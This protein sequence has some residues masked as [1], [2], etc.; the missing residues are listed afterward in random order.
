MRCGGPPGARAANTPRLKGKAVTDT[1]EP[2]LGP[3]VRDAR[4]LRPLV[5]FGAGG[6]AV[7]VANVALSAGYA[8]QHFVDQNRKGT[9]LLGIPVI[10]GIAELENP[11]EL[12]FAIAVGDNCVREKIHRELLATTPH[13]HFPPLVHPS[14][15]ISFFTEI[16]DGS[17]VMPQAV[18]G[19]HS[20]VGRFCLVNTRASIDHDCT[21]LDYSSLA[22]G[23]VTGG[24]VRIGLRS[25][26]SIGATV[27]HGLTIGDDSIVGAHS[28]LHR[29]LPDHQVAYGVPARPVRSRRAGDA[30]LK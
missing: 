12:S 24:T 22:P 7:S 9:A 20:R 27:K 10:G 15:V 2:H 18:V 4:K 14:A 13:L 28:Y 16:G 26:V 23:A 21:M 17:V 11:Q 1:E 6:H 8:I 30:Y 29:D 25:A 5:I 19:P 3:R